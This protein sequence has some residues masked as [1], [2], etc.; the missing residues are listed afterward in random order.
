MNG[1][2]WLMLTLASIIGALFLAT[3]GVILLALL[4]GN[5]SSQLTRNDDYGDYRD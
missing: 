1:L 4:L 3:T 5:I 2:S